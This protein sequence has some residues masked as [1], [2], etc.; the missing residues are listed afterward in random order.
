MKTPEDIVATELRNELQAR[1][2]AWKAEREQLTKAAARIAELDALIAFAEDDKKA[3][4]RVAPP[5]KAAED[6][7]DSPVRKEP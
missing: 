2:N 6:V 1:V 5:V 3:E 7:L 4:F